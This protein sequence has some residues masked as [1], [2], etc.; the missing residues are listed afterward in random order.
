M[1]LLEM[2]LKV[3]LALLVGGLV[4][5][6][7]E[8]RD[9]PAG[10]RT[11]MVVCAGS[12]LITL[13]SML[14]SPGDDRGRIAAQIVSGIGFLGAGTIFRSGNVVRGLTT[15]AGLWAVAGVG[16]AIAL[17]GELLYLAIVT[18]VLLAATNLGIGRLED[19]WVRSFED[20]LVTIDRSSDALSRA[21]EN[22]NER[23]VQIERIE[24][25][26]DADQEHTRVR[27]RLKLPPAAQPPEV[28]GWLT[29]LAGV[30]RVEWG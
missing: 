19:R 20:V 12:T 17:G 14:I 23:G 6:E 3:G 28:G 24:W 10:L 2:V 18:A 11:H 8:R 15:A 26:A 22:L 7:R 4:G 5:L 25:I 27:L 9:R 21:L 13:V 30:R 29:E 16:M 1:T